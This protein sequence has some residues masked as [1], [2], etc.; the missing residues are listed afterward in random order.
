MRFLLFIILAF[1]Y[2]NP[3]EAVPVDQNPH[4]VPVDGVMPIFCCCYNDFLSKIANY[5]TDLDISD[6]N[7]DDHVRKFAQA[8]F[9]SFGDGNNCFTLQEFKSMINSLYGSNKNEICYSSSDTTSIRTTRLA[10]FERLYVVFDTKYRKNNNKNNCISENQMKNLMTKV[11]NK[12]IWG[13]ASS[14]GEKFSQDGCDYG[15][16]Q[17]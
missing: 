11:R 17:K 15:Y 8:A 13:R 16:P 12:C 5:H 9:G 2:A 7:D 3:R 1:N 14:T 6:I 4:S 10:A